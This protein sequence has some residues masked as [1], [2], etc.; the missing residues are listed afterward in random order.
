[1]SYQLSE[2]QRIILDN[3]Y[4]RKNVIVNA[5]AG[6][7]KST[8][9]LSIAKMMPRTRF[10]Q[11]TYNSMLRKEFREKIFQAELDNVEVHTYHSLATKYYN[12][13]AHTDTKLRGIIHSRAKPIINIPQFDVVVLDEVQDCTLLY[14]QFVVYFIKEFKCSIQMLFLGDYMQKIYEFKGADCRFLTQAHDI[15]KGFSALKTQ[16]FVH[17]TLN[18]S[19]RITREM[20]SFIN[21]A[22][23]GEN[24]IIA[25]KNG[26]NVSYIRNPQHVLERIVVSRISKLLS[27][28]V[29]PNDIFI[30]GASVRGINSNIRR[31]ENALVDTGVPCH[32]PMMENRDID[33]RVIDGKIVFATF[34]ACKG[35]QRKYVF[36][37]GF[38][39]S[40]FSKYA[41]T[42]NTEICPNTLYVAATRATDGLYLLEIDQFATDRPLDFLKMGHYDMKNASYID[43]IGEPRSIFYK[44]AESDNIAAIPSHYTTPTE[45]IKFLPESVVETVSPI[46][47]SIF[48]KESKEEDEFIIDI[49]GV[50]ETITG[51]YEDVSDLNGIAI[52]IIYFDY[53]LDEWCKADH[54]AKEDD[55]D[56]IISDDECVDLRI[57]ENIMHENILYKLIYLNI[58]E[59]KA[60]SHVYLK[61]IFANLSPTC[62]TVSDYLYMANVCVATQEQ[63]YYRLKQIDR[64]EYTWLSDKIVDSCKA[65]LTSVIGDE[66]KVSR[67]EVEKTIIH[68]NMDDMHVN[69]DRVLA[70]SYGTD[71][72]FRFTAR[73]DLI[74]HSCI[75]ELK[76]TS[77]ISIDHL[78]QV[79]IYAWIWRLS[80]H[81]KADD[82]NK[83]IKILN[84]KTGEILRLDASIEQLTSIVTTILKAKYGS[85]VIIS[86]ND[87]IKNC[88]DTGIMSLN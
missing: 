41:R 70:A 84:I 32:V 43:F 77:N 67:P 73:T 44:H 8:T 46:L 74:S 54:L 38:D 64:S 58:H 18:T 39:N 19:Y 33:E 78:L 71:V 22:M 35:R 13:S 3:V 42:L 85:S 80:P 50:I 29:L 72:K 87:F 27:S 76:C 37:V 65:R 6:S 63:L 45:M 4:A 81:A 62:S 69:I 53:I 34:H 14:Y 83:S 20:A 59:M 51:F 75:W 48:V 7:G 30:L 28:G 86:D 55:E 49:P 23:L 15:W 16:E 26:Q 56:N 40:Y 82:V 31:I 17:C 12:P 9:I 60:N 1:M 57:P 25:C 2:E 10:L 61:E 5:V 47:D 24:R 68:H 79:V 21:N 52:P 11:I 36:V 88:R 66:C